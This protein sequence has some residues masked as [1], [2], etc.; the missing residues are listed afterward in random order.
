MDCPL[1]GNMTKVGTAFRSSIP[2]ADVTAAGLAYYIEATDGNTT[3]TYPATNPAASPQVITL[4]DVSVLLGDANG[5]T[6]VNVLDMTRVARIILL[7]DD[8][9]PGA[10]ADE[11]GFVNILDMTKIARIILGLD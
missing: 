5:D 9:T 7:L 11:N 8:E 1:E 4:A 6:F 10:D 2:V 3:A